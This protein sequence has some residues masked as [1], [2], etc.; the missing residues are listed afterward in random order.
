MRFFTW[1]FGC[2]LALSVSG[3]ELRFN[4]GDAAEGGSP[5]NFHA[6][7]AGN[8]AP[9]A[10]K[11]ITTET[12]SAF[13]SFNPNTP[14]VNRSKALAQTSDDMTDERF[15]MF[16]FDGETFGDIKFS[17]RFKIVSGITEQ[18]AGLVFRFQ[19]SSNFYVVRASALGH[20]VRFYKVVNGLRS[21]PIGPLLNVTAGEWHSLAVHCEG[22]QIKVLYDDKQV[23]PTL[24]D[25]TFSE[26][27]IGFWT[28]SDSVSYFT[29]ASV[30]Y[31]PRIP[32]AQRIVDNFME[33]KPSLHGLRIYTLETDGTTRV[34]ASKVPAE[35]GQAGGEAELKAIQ[36]GTQWFG[37][38]H[39]DVVVTLAL[40]DH[41][42]E[43]IGAMRV[44]LKSFLGETQNNAVN[45][46]MQLRKELE[47]FCTT[48]NELRK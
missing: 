15:P 8:G 19:N 17:T 18:M 4:F 14:A 16:V 47:E 23:M 3:A 42:G 45:R 37:R 12:P 10:W 34:I 44:K 9:G 13:A 1:V 36:D 5:A 30:S 41:N 24:G 26:G 43:N 40:R 31:T 46:A 6:T 33:K 25:N 28:K 35:I 38:E 21:A 39:G 32:P 27:K 20:N 29:D 11:V 22:N 48:G 7:I 2:T